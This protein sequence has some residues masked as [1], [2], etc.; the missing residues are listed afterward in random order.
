MTALGQ[1]AGGVP[2][3]SIAQLQAPAVITANVRNISPRDTW[4][5]LSRKLRSVMT[6]TNSDGAT[7]AEQIGPP[8]SATTPTR[9]GTARPAPSHVKPATISAETTKPTTAAT[10]IT[11]QSS[12][13]TNLSSIGA[14]EYA[15]GRNR[16]I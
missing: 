2:K 13:A 14:A 9:M 5:G 7:N 3:I 15:P 8:T 11:F 16:P 6:R 1:R 4:P 12:R 10:A